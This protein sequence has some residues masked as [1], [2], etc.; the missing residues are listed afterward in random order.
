MSLVDRL[1]LERWLDP[2]PIEVALTIQGRRERL[3]L[4]LEKGEVH[5]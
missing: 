5:A 2:G 1:E 4:T 3:G